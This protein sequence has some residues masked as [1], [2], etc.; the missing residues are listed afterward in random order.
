LQASTR[1]VKSLAVDAVGERLVVL[2]ADAAGTG[3]LVSYSLA[4]SRI[5]Q[6]ERAD[7]YVS[8][9]AWLCQQ[10]AGLNKQLVGCWNRRAVEFF[11]SQ[12][13]TREAS[14]AT[15]PR[16]PDF[17]AGLML[18]P[19]DGLTF[20]GFEGD[21]VAHYT[22]YPHLEIHQVKM[23]GWCPNPPPDSDFAN[24]LLAWR[25]SGLEELK[26]AGVGVGGV[27]NHSLLT[28]HNGNLIQ[29]VTHSATAEEKYRAVAFIHTGTLAAVTPSAVHW[30][31]AEATGLRMKLVTNAS[32]PSAIACFPHPAHHELIVVCAE[33]SVVRLPFPF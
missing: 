25:Q 13:L 14:L 3:S 1:C 24:T 8:S 31:Q 7:I 16:T 10:M 26:L 32:L 23:L 30:L 33:G 12:T 4:G 18:L 28:F 17:H 15:L 19:A 22:G 6:L 21:S 9:T 11:D 5:T 27:L 2:E 20:L 29:I